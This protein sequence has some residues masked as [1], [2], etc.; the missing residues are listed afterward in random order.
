MRQSPPTSGGSETS[1]RPPS[2]PP[3]PGSTDSTIKQSRE[4]RGLVTTYAQNRSWE[5]RL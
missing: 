2:R 3:P 5:V 4:Q 1:L